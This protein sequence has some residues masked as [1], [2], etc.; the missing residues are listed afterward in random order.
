MDW[1]CVSDLVCLVLS[2]GRVAER[3][4]MKE[5]EMVEEVERRRRTLEAG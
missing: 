5:E 1:G 3:E 4:R 2:S